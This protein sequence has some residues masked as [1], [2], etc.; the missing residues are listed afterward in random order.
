MSEDADV[1]ETTSV[2]KT[3]ESPPH[4]Q[5]CQNRVR[6]V[7]A[8]TIVMPVCRCSL[9]RRTRSMPSGV[10]SYCLAVVL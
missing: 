1:G 3:G 4:T 6:H 5:F 10:L 7:E 9:S 8:I 2:A